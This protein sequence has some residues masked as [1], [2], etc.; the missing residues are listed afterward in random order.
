MANPK[1]NIS[2]LDFDSIKTSLK[3]YLST[4]P[5]FVG[6][7]FEGAGVNTLLDVLSY[8]TLYYSFYSNMIANETFLDTAQLENNIVSLVKPLGY[9][10]TGKSC[11]K[12]EIV[13]KSV[14][15]T[16]VLLAYTDYF[17]GS[18]SSG[19][20]YR[21]YPIQDQ[22]LTSG[23]TSSFTL[24]EANSVVDGLQVTVDIAQQKAFLG[25]T[26]IDLNTL[27]VKVNGVAW[28]KFNNYQVDQGPDGQIY[29]LDRT[30]NGFY[31][32]FG[33]RTL[34]DYQTTYGKNIAEN[35][36]V[37]VSYLIPS[38]TKA[39]GI[40]SIT[41]NKVTVTSSSVSASGTDAVDLNLIKFFAPKLF[42]ANDR[43]VT[44]DDFYG[45]LFSSNILPASITQTTQVNVW[46]GEEADPASFGRV[47]V[48]YADPT[49]TTTTSSVKNSI[50]FLKSKSVVTVLPEYV[51]PQVVTINI[52]ILTTGANTAQ[53]TGIKSLVES[54]YNDNYKFNNSVKLIDVKNLIINNY[55]T[56]KGVNITSGGLKVQVI[57]SGSDRVIYL[58]NEL[59]TPPTTV[60]GV[61]TSDS[62][63]YNSTTIKLADKKIT[64]TS[65]SL[66]AV[67]TSG[68]EQTALGILG[69]VDYSTGAIFIKPN[70][71]STG[72][73]IN[74][75]ANLQYPDSVTI[76]NEF[77]GIVSATVTGA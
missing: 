7:D 75:T 52:G 46:G 1:I 45:L 34:N 58:K 10:V 76:K 51:Q 3:G 56:V 14:A 21:F 38:G 30:S 55:T 71:L 11:S 2:S 23:T 4:L 59:Q 26:N 60:G 40:S 32:I 28:N 66:V 27:T 36:V 9:L 53:L 49:L 57:G 62:F 8:N 65:G 74:V 37:T 25:N 44:K 24:Y 19:T 17:L 18:S 47:F 68:V 15:T 20:T 69:S 70:V 67:N 5:Q 31:I 77:L 12:T 54:Y 13:A 63:T 6:Y 61:V 16:N 50:A 42:A 41:N 33:K 43:A 22:T 39:N 48:S 64:N 73:T 35:D 72:T 29:F